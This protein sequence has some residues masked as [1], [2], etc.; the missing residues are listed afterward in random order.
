MASDRDR[1]YLVL[2]AQ[3]NAAW[4]ELLRHTARLTVTVERVTAELD[5]QEQPNDGT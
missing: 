1:D 5:D 4:Q 3:R 2:L